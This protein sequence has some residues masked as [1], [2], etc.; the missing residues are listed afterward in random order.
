MRSRSLDLL[1]GARTQPAT[2]GFLHV[3]VI[4]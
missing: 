2:R 3:G 4:Q 1:I